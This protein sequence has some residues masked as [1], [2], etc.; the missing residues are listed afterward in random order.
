MAESSCERVA[1]GGKR[2]FPW[3]C[4]KRGFRCITAQTEWT[5][6]ARRP[7][8]MRRFVPC[9]FL[10]LLTAAVALLPA[11]GQQAPPTPVAPARHVE[12][13]PPKA[14]DLAKLSPPQQT[15]YRSAHRGM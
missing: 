6:G 3:C 5:F 12:T 8:P 1:C 11:L 14:R 7:A 15:F 2:H 10:L 9:A 13:S 4:P